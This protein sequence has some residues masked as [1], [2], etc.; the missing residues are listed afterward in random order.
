VLKRPINIYF[1]TVFC[2]VYIH[3]FQQT[4]HKK[5]CSVVTFNSVYFIQPDITN[6]KFASEDFTIST[7]MTS[8]TF[9]LTSD[10]EKLPSNR[11]GISHDRR[12]QTQSGPMELEICDGE[13]KMHP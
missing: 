13:M 1:N 7:H 10:Q 2:K 12:L 4:T 9:V 3:K 5:R 6:D 11:N 8:L